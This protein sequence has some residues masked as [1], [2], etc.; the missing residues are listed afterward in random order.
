MVFP[1]THNTEPTTTATTTELISQIC[2]SMPS[3]QEANATELHRR[4]IPIH[5]VANL[6]TTASES[7][8]A[9]SEFMIA[10]GHFTNRTRQIRAINLNPERRT[11]LSGLVSGLYSAATTYARAI[12]PSEAMTT[13]TMRALDEAKSALS[14]AVDN[15]KTMTDPTDANA[16]DLIANFVFAAVTVEYANHS[17]QIAHAKLKNAHDAISTFALANLD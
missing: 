17:R 1:M 13:D 11:S 8:S 15:A 5:L 12:S 10:E 16:H 3:Q 7:Q 14:T 6:V 2:H 9:T 4:G